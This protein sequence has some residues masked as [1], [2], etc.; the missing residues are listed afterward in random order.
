M[1]E[2]KFEKNRFKKWDSKYLKFFIT[3]R[4]C[5]RKE[6]STIQPKKKTLEEEEQEKQLLKH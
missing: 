4:G 5:C 1:R 6:K 2:R 3:V